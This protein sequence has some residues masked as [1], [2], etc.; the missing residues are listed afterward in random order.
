V[1]VYEAKNGEACA[2]AGQ[3]RGQ[4][5]GLLRDGVFRPYAKN[6]TGA[7]GDLGRQPY[8]TSVVAFSIPEKRT[9]IFGRASDRVRDFEITT[10]GK[11]HTAV[12]GPDGAFLFV[13][14]GRYDPRTE[15]LVAHLED[16]TTIP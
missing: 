16:G 6:T 10:S 3:V 7:C 12:P 13:L 1:G 11:R 14:S 5:I 15:P 2:T 4:A 8:F 9:L